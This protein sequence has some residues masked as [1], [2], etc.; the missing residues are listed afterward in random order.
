MVG[1]TLMDEEQYRIE[2]WESTL[3]G[4]TV[5]WRASVPGMEDYAALRKQRRAERRESWQA[6]EEPFHQVQREP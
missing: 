1:S 2:R 5:Y 6:W 3:M 4:S